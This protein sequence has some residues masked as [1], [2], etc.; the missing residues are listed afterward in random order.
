[1]QIAWRK[2]VIKNSV[3]ELQIEHFYATCNQE[4]TLSKLG[5]YFHCPIYSPQSDTRQCPPYK[6]EKTLNPLQREGSWVKGLLPGNHCV[7]SV[8]YWFPQSWFYFWWMVSRFTKCKVLSTLLQHHINL[9]IHEE[10]QTLTHLNKLLTTN[11]I[12]IYLH[13]Y[14]HSVNSIKD[15]ADIEPLTA[16]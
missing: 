2:Q 14:L 4:L 8:T 13:L 12:P 16:P 3:L 9:Y 10:I 15:Q 5:L 11:S 6:Q 1:M 7:K